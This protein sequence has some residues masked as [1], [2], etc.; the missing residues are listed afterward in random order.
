[1]INKL[2]ELEKRLNLLN[3]KKNK[4]NSAQ[5]LLTLNDSEVRR[6]YLNVRKTI[7]ALH[8][9]NI[10]PI[11]NE[12]DTV[13]TEEIRYGDND[14]LASRVAQMIDADLLILLSDV[15]GN[16]VYTDDIDGVL[17]VLP[18]T[19]DASY[20]SLS[21]DYLNF[22]VVTPDDSLSMDLTFINEGSDD[23]IV[24]DI[25]C[26]APFFTVDDSL[27]LSG[28][29]S[30]SST[31]WFYPLL[32]GAYTE[33]LTIHT[34][35][36]IYTVLLY[37]VGTDDIDNGFIPDIHIAESELDFGEIYLGFDSTIYITVIN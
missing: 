34:S 21:A 29:S 20:L 19:G 27:T 22:G 17:T 1:M 23:I 18:S 13:A 25:D 12:N 5:I 9:K 33:T 11:I 26:P 28:G 37:G 2:N 35:D 8:K 32:E 4:I 16:N 3:L 14:R 30:H 24:T 7:N 36:G 10:I 15:D 6:H 31:I